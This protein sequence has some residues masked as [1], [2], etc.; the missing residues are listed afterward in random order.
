MESTVLKTNLF[1]LI[2]AG[3][4]TFTD[5]D[6]LR[7]VCDRMLEKKQPHDIIIVS[8]TAHG[9]DSLGEK[10]AKERNYTLVQFPANWDR[11]GK[12]AGYF[13]NAMMAD[14]ADALIA[15][16]DEK[17]RGTRNMIGVMTLK[18]KPIRKIIFNSEQ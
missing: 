14:Y 16:W 2:I 15:F 9:A 7:E 13:R 1:K 5:Y 18:E 12:G 10:Y 6:R 11:H 4:R 3:S 17:S 8:G